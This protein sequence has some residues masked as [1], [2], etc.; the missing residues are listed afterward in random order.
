MA[1]ALGVVRMAT[2]S[3]PTAP[4]S[5]M[6]TWTPTPPPPPPG[7]RDLRRE[8]PF[9]G[10]AL[11]LL[12]IAIGTLVAAAFAS[13]P[14]SCISNTQSVAAQCPSLLSNIAWALL[15]ARVLWT[16]GLLFL[17]GGAALRLHWLAPPTGGSSDEYRWAQMTR[18]ANLILIVLS[19]VLLWALFAD[20]ST[21]VTLAG[22]GL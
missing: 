21:T 10:R 11:G 20:T 12:L 3:S 22:A 6:P 14:G 5:S 13:V 18:W 16:L 1:G 8:A 17:I 7:V 9:W 15:A 2:P 4:T 19:I